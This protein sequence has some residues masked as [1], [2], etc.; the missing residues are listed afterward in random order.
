MSSKLSIEELLSNLENRVVFHRDQEAFH[1]QQEVH[2]REQRTVHAAELEKV[3]QN[4]EA[5]RPVAAGVVEIARPL[6]PLV[7]PE[8]IPVV[9][10]EL[11]PPGRHRIGRFLR[12]VA[13][14]PDLEEPFSPT[15]VAEE[16][17]RRYAAHLRNPIGS[18]TASDV[19]RRMLA[20]GGLQ[21]VN[22]GKAFHEALYAR[23]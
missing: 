4:L 8:P 2:H 19:L 13:E 20:E 11:P 7:P 6:E 21:R 16:A 22:K 18:R 9:E 5:F 10:K 14:S 3:L 15:D 23:K 17:N 1:A 12:L